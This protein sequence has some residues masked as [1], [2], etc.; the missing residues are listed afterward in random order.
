MIENRLSELL[1]AGTPTVEQ[2]NQFDE[3]GSLTN[4]LFDCAKIV[5]SVILLYLLFRKTV[6]YVEEINEDITVIKGGNLDKKVRVKGNDELS[7]LATTINDMT[8]T[9]N[10]NLKNTNELY[11]NI[12]H[13]IKTPITIASSYLHAINDGLYKDEKELKDYVDKALKNL[14]DINNLSNKV[15]ELDTIKTS[16]KK[17]KIKTAI[18][19]LKQNIDF[20]ESSKIEV[21]L[22]IDKAVLNDKTSI[23]KM[24]EEDFKSIIYNIIT[25]IKKYSLD[26]KANIDVLEDNSYFKLT[27]NNKTD[28]RTIKNIEKL[29]D[30]FYRTDEAR[31]DNSN[32]LGLSI[33]SK[34][35]KDNDSKFKIEAKDN[36]I[37]FNILIRKL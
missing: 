11:Q 4:F 12:S 10:N 33:V 31:S 3:I 1:A 17:T 30:R 32:G 2:I 22:T 19:L 26:Q 34:I 25:N 6:R 15:L 18:C 28:E 8:S 9:L 35:C 23:I 21:N 20:L 36:D 24:S 5:I 14:Q 7:H 16:N 13:D 37:I 27:F 29:T